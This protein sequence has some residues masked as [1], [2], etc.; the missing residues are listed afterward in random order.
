MKSKNYLQKLCLVIVLLF[1]A[2]AIIGDG[3]SGTRSFLILY[4]LTVMIISMVGV[5]RIELI[6]FYNAELLY[7][8]HLIKAFLFIFLL[9]AIFILPICLMSY[10]SDFLN[11]PKFSEV[12]ML[13]WILF[14]IPGV[15]LFRKVFD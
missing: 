10:Y 6:L 2:F 7:I 12:K 9:P 8:R 15:F 1:S 14:F 13:L 11:I 3:L 5:N 4:S